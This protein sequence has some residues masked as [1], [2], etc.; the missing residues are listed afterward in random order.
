[1]K[2]FADAIPAKPDDPDLE[3]AFQRYRTDFSDDVIKSE[4]EFVLSVIRDAR[5]PLSIIHGDIH[6]NNMVLDH[7]GKVVLI[8]FEISSISYRYFDLGYFFVMWRVAPWLR[9]CTPGE[10]ALTP[11]VRRQYIEAYLEAK[12]EHEGRDRKDVS[13]AE[14]EL[15]DLQH[16][17]I[18]FASIFDYIIEPLTFV[19]EPSVATEFLH[20]HLETKDM[21]F[22]LKNTIKDVIA[23]IVE[24]DKV[25]NG[26]WYPKT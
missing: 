9:W 3:E 11:E 17:V 1:M 6:K 21:Y 13:A 15:M 19:N 26:S 16:Q 25:V 12:C 5:L 20:F 8:D 18:E 2:V 23:R 14:Y 22:R 7:C 10:P 4:L 24:L